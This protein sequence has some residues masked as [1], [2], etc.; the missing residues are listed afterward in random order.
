MSKL[1]LRKVCVVSSSRADYGLLRST[2][3]IIQ[4]DS[5]LKLQIIATGMHLHTKYGNTYKEI[6]VDG[7]KI[8]HKVKML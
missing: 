3:Q 4:E 2:M 8:D 1:Y 7:F 6:E 5:K